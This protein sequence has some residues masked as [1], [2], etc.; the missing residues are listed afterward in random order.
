MALYSFAINNICYPSFHHNDA[1]KTKARIFYEAIMI[2]PYSTSSGKQVVY[3]AMD[4]KCAFHLAGYATAICL[5]N[6][7][8]QLPAVYFKIVLRQQGF[9]KTNKLVFR[10]D[11]NGAIV[12][13]GRLIQNLPLA[14]GDAAQYFSW[15]QLEQYRCAFE[16]DVINLLVGY[17]AETKFVAMEEDVVFNPHLVNLGA[18]HFYDGNSDFDVVSEYMSCF[19][20]HK[21]E[22]EQKLAEL[23]LAAYAFVDNSANWQAI[24][25]LA[26]FIAIVGKDSISCEEVMAV[27]ESVLA[28]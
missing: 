26:D 14:F 3:A 17:L 20:P 1:A 5:G 22:R 2:Q 9:Q 11:K 13:G 10:P 25:A 6:K 7:Q 16:A 15:V 12:E 23:F 8:K 4:R 27:I 19:M 18:L 21:H 24:V 28:A